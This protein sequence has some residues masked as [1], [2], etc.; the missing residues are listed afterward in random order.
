MVKVVI[1]KSKKN[2]GGYG[3]IS[4]VKIEDDNHLSQYNMWAQKT[5]KTLIYK[6]LGSMPML[7]YV[8]QRRFSYELA[9]FF[10]EI[11]E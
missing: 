10:L 1:L 8:Y 11:S 2:L 5:P 7:M 4:K 6:K 9:D 3:M